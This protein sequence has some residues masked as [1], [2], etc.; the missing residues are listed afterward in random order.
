MGSPDFVGGQM[1]NEQAK[2]KHEQADFFTA[3]MDY[4]NLDQ[5]ECPAIYHRWGCASVIGTLLGRNVW[6]P[7]G[8][9]VIYPN[10]YIMLMGP[11][12]SK[13]GTAIGICKRVLR[14]VGYTRFAADR[15]SKEAFLKHM[16]QFEADSPEGIAEL[17]ALVLNAPSETYICAGE[18]VDFIGQG[19]TGFMMT[20]TNLW[21]NLPEY[22]HPKITGK[23]VRVEKP[24]VNMFGGS[25]PTNFAVAFPPEAIGSGFLSR[26]LLIHSDGSGN[27]IPWPAQPDPLKQA[28]LDARLKEIKQLRGEMRF[29]ESAHELIGDIYKKAV[30]IDDSRFAHYMER[31]HTHLIKLS[32]IVAIASLRLN[33]ENIDVI[34]ANTMLA[35]AEARMGKALGEFGASKYAAASNTVLEVLRHSRLPMNSGDIWKHVSRDIT[36]MQELVDIL[37]NLKRSDKIQVLQL[38]GKTGYVPH[39]K[40]AVVWD[41]AYIDSGWLTPQENFI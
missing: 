28:L 1:N 3:Y 8:H 18:F 13:K 27:K 34:R 41:P 6:V 12:A 20:L 14:E 35:A 10:Q 19:D 21:D 16:K 23:D 29:S 4:V 26:V 2:G 15:T 11:P 40:P 37:E 24:T 33:I 31:R 5:S 36:K 7:F 17:E 38:K 9:S 22:I 32:M 25:T 30:P 39:N